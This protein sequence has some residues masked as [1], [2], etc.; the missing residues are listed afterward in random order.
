MLEIDKEVCNVVL[1]LVNVDYE[2]CNM[3][4][5]FDIAD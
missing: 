1:R 2:V 4:I 5:R 3:A